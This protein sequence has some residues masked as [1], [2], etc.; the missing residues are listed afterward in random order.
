M[1]KNFFWLAL[2]SLLGIA[3]S[4]YVLRCGYFIYCYWRLDAT[5]PATS[6]TWS[7]VEQGSSDYQL[8]ADYSY[9]VN[10]VS[11]QGRD[12]PKTLHYENPWAANRKIEQILHHTPVL[13]YRASDPSVSAL[14][15]FFPLKETLYTVC[16][17]ALLG[18]FL[19][20]G[21]YVGRQAKLQ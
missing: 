1:H 9:Q 14:E 10:G 12:L 11:Y 16:L 2:L 18:Y 15:R 21:Y 3:T 8:Q 6:I 20:L 17:I 7:F 13:W 5:T 4:M 19:G